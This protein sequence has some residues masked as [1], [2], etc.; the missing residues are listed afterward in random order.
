[1]RWHV[2]LHVQCPP[3]VS[4]ALEQDHFRSFQL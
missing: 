4:I 3:R 2:R 1:V